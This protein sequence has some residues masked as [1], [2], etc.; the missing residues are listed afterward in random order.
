MTEKTG[1][2][3][4]Y[5]E[6]KTERAGFIRKILEDNKIAPSK[7]LT[8]IGGAW[9]LEFRDIFPKAKIQAFDS[10]ASQIKAFRDEILGA[11]GREPIKCRAPGDRFEDVL[12]LTNF[13]FLVLSNITDYISPGEA[14]RLGEEIVEFEVPAVLFSSLG[15]GQMRSHS[16][17]STHTLRE[18][19]EEEGYKVLQF[20]D[21]TPGSHEV[22]NFY[23]ATRVQAT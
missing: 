19:L 9:P 2:N 10:N 12:S 18:H 5:Y 23:L 6:D 3:G 17:Q 8:V 22:R 14:E 13:D 16:D 11:T 20:T 7:I 1:E 4:V 15:A 21:D